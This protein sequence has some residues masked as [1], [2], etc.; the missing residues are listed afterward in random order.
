MEL[1]CVCRQWEHDTRPDARTLRWHGGR[2]LL[3]TRVR[4]LNSREDSGRGSCL[5]TIREEERVET[6]K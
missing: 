5:L 1:A 6:V 2:S 3:L 4:R